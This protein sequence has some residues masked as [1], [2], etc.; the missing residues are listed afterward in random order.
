[1]DLGHCES[2]P[3]EGSYEVDVANIDVQPK[4]PCT[5]HH[6]SGLAL[7]HSKVQGERGPTHELWTVNQTTT[8]WWPKT[9]LWRCLV[10]VTHP[11]QSYN[12]YVRQYSWCSLCLPALVQA[13]LKPQLFVSTFLVKLWLSKDL[14]LADSF[15]LPQ[16]RCLERW[17]FDRNLWSS[18][19][20][21]GQ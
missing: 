10:R 1:M 4:G 13:P 16:A 2:K 14:A 7:K 19:T 3:G 8:P 6:T 9:S 21:Q 12:F 15:S 17:I 18:Q 20:P 5:W 11:P